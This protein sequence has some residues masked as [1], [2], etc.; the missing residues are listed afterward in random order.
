MSTLRRSF[1]I[2]RVEEVN[3]ISK[4]TQLAIETEKHKEILENSRNL[5]AQ[6]RITIIEDIANYEKARDIVISVLNT[7]QGGIKTYLE[8]IVTQ[9]LQCIFGEEYRFEVNFVQKR[10]KNEAEFYVL[11]GGLR[12]N[13]KYDIEAGGIIDILSL[14][15]RMAIWSMRSPKSAPVFILDEPGKWLSAALRPKFGKL[16]KEL[17]TTLGVQFIIVSHDDAMIESA[18]KVFDVELVEGCSKVTERNI[19]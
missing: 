18:D 14:A 13:P 4:Y 8:E 7:T 6:K 12:L 17:S 11:K 15:L 2:E 1:Q 16:I 3:N 10:N 19:L 9:A 5:L